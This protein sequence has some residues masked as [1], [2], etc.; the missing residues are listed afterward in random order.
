[1]Q[2]EQNC[3]GLNGDLALCDTRP[4]NVDAVAFN[5]DGTLLGSG[6]RA[7]LLETAVMESV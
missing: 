5:R 3:R 1:L 6:G 7:G 2:F 4:G